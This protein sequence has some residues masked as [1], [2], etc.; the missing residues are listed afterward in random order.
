[1]AKKIAYT[2]SRKGFRDVI[3]VGAVRAWRWR[4]WPRSVELKGTMKVAGLGPAAVYLMLKA[5]GDADVAKKVVVSSAGLPNNEPLADGGTWLSTMP[6][7]VSHLVDPTYDDQTPRKTSRLFVVVERGQWVA[8]LKDL[9]QGLI[10][11]VTVD[12][13]EQLFPALEALLKSDRPPW[14]VDPWAK[15]QSFKKKK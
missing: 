5:M 7:L 6:E 13:P 2:F 10:L 1:M 15:A 4:L 14:R 9:N 12:K 8:T 11:E 3:A